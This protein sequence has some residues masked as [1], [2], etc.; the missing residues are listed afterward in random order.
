M[1]RFLSRYWFPAAL[2]LLLLMA[3]PG[4][5]LLA[6]HLFGQEAAVSAWLQ[7]HWRISYH[8][9]V[10]WWAGIVLL[11]V[12]LLL[13]LL[14]FLKLKRKPL[15]V[16][17]TF[18]WK[19]SVEDLHVNSMF[20]WLRENVLLLLQ[21]LTL[22][23]LI[24]A[25]MAFQFH[26]KSS[27]GEHYILMVDNSA[28]MAATD[29]APSR[30]HEAKRMA[31][32]EVDGRGDNDVGMVIVF[33]SSAE[34]LQSY[35][36][37]KGLLRAAIERIEQTERLTRIDDALSLADSLAN[38]HRAPEDFA[39]RPEGAEPGK[40]RTYVP[41][42]GIPTTLHVFTDGRFPDVPE[43]ALG[44][45]Q[46]RYHSVGSEQVENIGIVACSA[47]R[48]QKDPNAV[49]VLVGVRNFKS[50]E[51]QVRVRLEVSVNGELQKIYEEP[52]G[53]P[54]VLPPRVVGEDSASLRVEPGGSPGEGFVTFQ[55]SNLDDRA[56]A[57][58]RATLVDNHDHFALDDEAWLVV[59]VVR[60]ARVLIVSPHNP[61]LHAFFDQP[62]AGKLAK[63]V[64]LAPE[65][66]KDDN[67][68]R[69]PARDGAYDLIIFDRCAPE[70]EAELPLANTFFIDSVPPPWKR[71]EMKP[72]QNTEIKGRLKDH[73][74]L[75]YLSSV[76]TIGLT[77]AFRFDLKDSRVPPRT[78]R[79][80]ETD[81]ET[82]VL[83][84]LARQSFT[85]LVMT[86]PILNSEGK[87]TTTWPLHLGFPLFLTNVVTVLGNV[88]DGTE[89][90]IV[91][92]GGAKV[93]R[94]DRAMRTIEVEGPD[95]KRETVSRSLRVDFVHGPLP[96]VGVYHVSWDGQVQT[97]FAVNLL[98][99]AESDLTPRPSIDIGDERIVAG[100][101][102]STPRD[103]WKW[104]AL[105][106]LLLL[107]LEWYIYN[108]RVYI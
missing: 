27:E 60:K 30:L 40:E 33:N 29:V 9:P 105:A 3:L 41:A 44:N 72:L 66:L 23:A 102:R 79:L 21:L 107:L 64:Y 101:T 36:S 43:F 96:R 93:I 80:I 99:S 5:I 39:V 73:P 76:H 51:A 47:T 58:L 11:L 108:R 90:E 98:D 18:L 94:P 12:P 87:W 65:D 81:R 95:G 15:Q 28:S 75:R 74:L 45:L 88:E 6:I 17:S 62:S 86:F 70:T 82:A 97:A 32:Q 104:I 37:D 16:P 68:Y 100:E 83:F 2:I 55:V 92:P 67:K 54:L 103:V 1:M 63:V 24:Y 78:P 34:I 46:A 31:L 53:G 19:K 42:E 84:T 71:S 10:P 14:Y 91:H 35:T 69:K 48:S 89:A 77:E 57:V 59:G 52:Q 56:G 8:L 85:D 22:L 7:E 49:Q 4:I 106:A 20:Q 38:P 61:A 26:G 25:V 13:I 50:K